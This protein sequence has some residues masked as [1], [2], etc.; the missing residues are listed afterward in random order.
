MLRVLILTTPEGRP[1]PRSIR[2]LSRAVETMLTSS[3]GALP[4]R[5]RQRLVFLILGILLSG[6]LVLRRIATT[7]AYL[8]P[9]TTCAASHERRLRRVLNDPLLTWERSY[10]RAVRRLL[11][12][13][14]PT[15]WVI[16]VDETAQAEHWRVLTAA[17]AYRGRAIPLAWVLWPGQVKQ[18]TVYWERCTVL[19]DQVAQVLPDGASVVVVADRGFGCP[20]FTDQVAARGW[21][22]L[23]RVQGQTRWRD[24]DRGAQPVRAQVCHPGDRWHGRG[25]VFKDAGWRAAQILALWGAGHREPLLLVASL[26]VTGDLRALYQRRAAIETLFRD[27][28]SAGWQWEASQVR[29]GAHH[30]RLLLGLAFATLVTLVLGSQAAAAVQQ[31]TGRGR[32]RQAWACRSSLFRLGR[33][34]FWQ[35]VWRGDRTPIRW[36]LDDLEGANW[37]ATVHAQHAAA[38]AR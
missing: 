14:R 36:A 26:G 34:A 27:W 33:E 4:V 23:V 13:Q 11:A 7:H 29:D 2:H 21:D 28:K 37:S 32:P 8:T 22:W 1:M 24:G 30:A 3:D 5:T 9:H 12:R 17:L 31:T 15:R 25:Q 20:V 18:T 19:L 10:A 35:R 38:G 6:T 16:L